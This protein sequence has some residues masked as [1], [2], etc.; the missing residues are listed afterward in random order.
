M[1]HQIQ[2]NRLEYWIGQFARNTGFEIILNSIMN[3]PMGKPR[4]ILVLLLCFL[5]IDWFIVKN[6]ISYS[7]AASVRSKLN[8]T[9]LFVAVYG[10][11]LVDCLWSWSSILPL[12][13]GLREASLD[14]VDW[15]EGSL[16]RS[17]HPIHDSDGD[18]SH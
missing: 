2:I 1:E 17:T 11:S 8:S 16:I 9:N 6:G 12:D 18:V 3:C 5:L 13:G 10:T 7:D 14:L 15:A 4:W